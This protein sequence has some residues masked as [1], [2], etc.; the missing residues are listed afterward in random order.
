MDKITTLFPAEAEPSIYEIRTLSGTRYEIDLRVGGRWV[1]R[2]FPGPD[3]APLW[4]D[5][6][7]TFRYGL[8]SFVVG[9][10]ATIWLRGSGWMAPDL[11]AR[12]STI[13]SITKLD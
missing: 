13:V 11:W 10:T 9:N 6:A 5:E 3:S 7:T 8:P 12:C 2:R 4:I 1:V